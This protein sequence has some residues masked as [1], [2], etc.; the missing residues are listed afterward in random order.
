M[1]SDA[2]V[3]YIDIFVKM[4]LCNVDHLKSGYS[5]AN[6]VAYVLVIAS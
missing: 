1:L 6:D 4:M 5:I 2:V 3:D